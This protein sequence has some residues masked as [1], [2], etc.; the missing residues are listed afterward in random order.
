MDALPYDVEIAS[1]EVSPLLDAVARS[2]PD[3]V[4]VW[5][6]VRDESGAI[7]DFVNLVAND[8]ACELAGMPASEFAGMSL[9][10]VITIPSAV[11]VWTDVL[12]KAVDG[13]EPILVSRRAT[14]ESAPF[15][16]FVGHWFDAVLVPAGDDLA[17]TVRDRSEAEV[18]R[19]QLAQLK[20]LRDVAIATSP[21]GVVRITPDGSMLLDANPAFQRLVGLSGRPG[22][23]PWWDYLAGDAAEA[24]GSMLE[25]LRVG[26]VPSFRVE[27][28]LLRHGREPLGVELMAAGYHNG[29]GDLTEVLVQVVDRADEYEAR[30]EAQLVSEEFRLLAENASDLVVR[31]DPAGLITWASPSSLPLLGRSAQDVAGLSLASIVRPEDARATSAAIIAALSGV[32]GGPVEIRLAH[33]EA[34]GAW[35]SLATRPLR[36]DNREVAGAIVTLR[37]IRGEMEARAALQ[38]AS[39]TD[40]VTGLGTRAVALARL[41]AALE[42]ATPVAMVVVGVDHLGRFNEALSYSA[43][44]LV[45]ATV[46]GRL[47]EVVGGRDDVFRITGGEFAV[48]LR[49][50]D[51]PADALA[52]AE[53]IRVSVGAP[54]SFASHTLSPTVSLG[55]A[56]SDL[57]EAAVVFRDADLAM[58]SAKA[59][60]RNQCVFA[61]PRRAEQAAARL[62]DESELHQALDE[63]RYTAHFQPIVNLADR[64]LVGFEALARC[65][66]RD[67]SIALDPGQMAIAESSGRVREIDEVSLAEA[68]SLLQRLPAALTV[69]VNVSVH[70][71]RSDAYL[72]RV[73]LILASLEIDPWRLHLEVT[74]S[75]ALSVDGSVLTQME[76]LTDAG[77]TWYLDDFGTGFSSLASLRDLPMG[78]L[79]LD[80]GFT[81]G[82]S[83]DVSRG[84]NLTHGLVVLAHDLA[85][86][87]VAEG[88]E[89]DEQ[90]HIL[91][92]Q[93]WDFGQGWLFG[94]PMS[95]DAAV[96]LAQ[97]DV[98]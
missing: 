91:T 85:L 19:S 90:A 49:G 78:G 76:R 98:V 71:L 66:Q 61:D 46:A 39:R 10:A 84:R 50:V 25:R 79:K 68:V 40:P 14:A 51:S 42:A 4:T 92:D 69:A 77:I 11:A 33:A 93:G 22:G 82:L 13:G 62:R 35:M 34:P 55:I 38:A 6:A 64:R 30:H 45:L 37:D 17:I 23:Q 63:G 74:E 54:L 15:Q 56:M 26:S 81:T 89:T 31:L 72:R 75:T 5:R 29:E 24:F 59:Q 44:D 70:S 27:S 53:R 73:E 36:T 94:R 58:R 9:G 28:V 52:V 87:T 20:A 8:P 2:V 96:L 65:Q 41:R 21:S 18:L 88:V 86:E 48:L 67:G 3:P 60:G 1:G 7:C 32:P 80:R 97:G 95:G 47:A 12:A 43:G 57:G 83:A 16:G